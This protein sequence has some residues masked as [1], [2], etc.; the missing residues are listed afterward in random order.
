MKNMIYVSI[1]TTTVLVTNLINATQDLF[2][3]RKKNPTK[4]C[5]ENWKK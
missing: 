5:L 1:K 4:C 3:K 2:T